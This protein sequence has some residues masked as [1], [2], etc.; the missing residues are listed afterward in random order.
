[1]PHNKITVFQ[2]IRYHFDNLI[3]KGTPALL[4]ML[5]ISFLIVAFITSLILFTLKIKDEAGLD[6]TFYE[7]YWSSLMHVIDQGT[8]TGDTDWQLRFAT[9]ATTFIGIFLV[10]LLVTIL[11]NGFST[12]LEEL[13]K[14]RSLVLEEGHTVILGWSSKVFSII[15]ELM[16]AHENQDESCIVILADTD[17]DFMKDEIKAKLGST[18]K[19]KV[20]VRHG[21]QRDPK[22]IM[23]TN[24]NTAKSIIILSPDDVKSDAYVIKTILAI[25]NN[26]NRK[27]DIYTIIA[28]IKNETN[29]EIAKIIGKEEVTVVVSN[30]IISKITV[31]TSR[32]SGL[33]LIYNDLIDY[34]GVEIYILPVKNIAGHTFKEAMFAFEDVLAIGIRKTDGEIILNPNVDTIM[35]VSDKLVVIAEDDIDLTFVPNTNYTPKKAEKELLTKN[36]RTKK[37][38]KTVILGWNGNTKIIVRELDNYVLQ[39]SEVLIIAEI[40]NLEDMVQ[41]LDIETPNQKVVC[42][43][44][45]IN[46]R[47]L[48]NKLNLEFYDDII[49]NSY[50]DLYGTQEADAVTLIT[51]MHV[52]DI[53][54]KLDKK[55]N[56]V[57][58]MLD[59]K[60]QQLADKHHVDDFIVSDQ[61]ISLVMAQLSENKELASIFEDIFDA[62]GNEIYLKPAS[63]YAKLEVPVNFYEIS[64]V[65]L[66]KKEIAI[67][68]RKMKNTSELKN[69]GIVLNPKKSDKITLSAEDKVI[70][71][72]ED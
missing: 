39:G 29:R 7:A 52:R 1:M 25:V 38:Q 53:A 63:N 27:K 21:N 12:K 70:V 36:Y 68:Y 58:E 28:E 71:I 55:F 22:D 11:N 37:I 20:I 41:E 10:S 45:D 51:L 44:G 65:A 56:I 24:L 9:L 6:M 16:I 14:G 49:I 13:K 23:I 40:D 26:A 15:S 8:I 46:D 47:S 34:T 4:S 64:D 54:S 60:N 72:S 61:I 2:R 3:G 43:R 30:D 57:S 67:G 32:Q 19:T 5:F 62:E 66:Q 31:Q 50:H 59:I 42:K 33:S 18:G 35:G 69:F 17:I 48:L